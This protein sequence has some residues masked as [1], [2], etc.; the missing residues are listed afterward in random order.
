V[1]EDRGGGCDVEE[2]GDE[3]RVCSNRTTCT[4]VYTALVKEAVEYHQEEKRI[5][6]C[7]KKEP[8]QLHWTYNRLKR[9]LHKI[10]NQDY[11]Y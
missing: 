7:G 3:R 11:M 1:G 5:N 2:A 6:Y 8:W 9:L 10:R 4:C